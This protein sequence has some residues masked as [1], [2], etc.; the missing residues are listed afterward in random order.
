[1]LRSCL[2]LHVLPDLFRKRTDRTTVFLL[3]P[4]PGC[5]RRR[6]TALT[7]ISAI[8]QSAKSD[9]P[10]RWPDPAKALR[11][12]GPKRPKSTSSSR[13]SVV[14]VVLFFT[15]RRLS[16]ADDSDRIRRHLGM[17]DVEEP[18]SLRV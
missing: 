3:F 12:T 18:S 7:G 6:R 11:R 13:E 8:S 2:S 15:L 16:R 5:P 14:L 17:H 1:M 9:G 10:P 4:F